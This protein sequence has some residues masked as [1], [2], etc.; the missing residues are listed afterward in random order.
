[1]ASLTETAYYTRRTV[2]WTILV[3]IGYVVLRFAWGIFS[4][5]YL[6]VFPPKPQ[7]AN[8]AFGKLPAVH[9]PA[10]MASPS[11]QLIYQLETIEVGPSCIGICE[12]LLHA[13]NWI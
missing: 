8:H 12:C 11:G 6:A 1:M 9:F 7:A 4:T 3:I 13:K 5:A 10:P 2:N